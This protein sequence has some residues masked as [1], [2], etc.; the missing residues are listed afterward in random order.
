MQE[1]WFNNLIQP[2]IKENFKVWDILCHCLEEIFLWLLVARILVPGQNVKT[3]NI[4]IVRTLRF[5]IVQ[6]TITVNVASLLLHPLSNM[7]M[8]VCSHGIESAKKLNWKTSKQNYLNYN[9]YK[10]VLNI[11][12]NTWTNV[13]YIT[14]IYGAV[15]CSIVSV[16]FC[17]FS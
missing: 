14:F 2:E 10:D 17:Y 4:K 8:S 5:V 11:I 3:L 16:F 9:E 1:L 6:L 7:G 12:D 13:K 15:I